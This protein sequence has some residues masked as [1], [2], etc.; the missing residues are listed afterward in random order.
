MWSTQCGVQNVEYKMWRLDKVGQAILCQKFS[1]RCK[2]KWYDHAPD[3]VMENYQ[4]KVPWDFR[5]QTDHH[6]EHNRP[7]IVFLEEERTCSVKDV[8]CPFDT[9]VLEKEQEKMGK[10]QDLKREIEKIWNCKSVTVIPVIIGTISRNVKA[11]V[12]KFGLDD[13][14]SFLQ[15]AF[16][17][18]SARILRKTLDT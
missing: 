2:D 8:A 4:V 1:L 9:R 14:T 3:S 16:L 12:K 11:S 13:S 15:N 6:L 18:R 17:L 7:N 5:V 10:Y